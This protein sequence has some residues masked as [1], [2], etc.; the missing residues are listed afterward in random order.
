MNRSLILAVLLAAGIGVWL[1]SGEITGSTRITDDTTHAHAEKSDSPGTADATRQT[2]AAQAEEPRPA[3]PFRV[4][5]KRLEARMAA[6]LFR[7]QPLSDHK[8]DVLGINGEVGAAHGTALV[9]G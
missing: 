5:V 7:L 3:G 6:E 1:A 2:S 8:A 9:K 4:R